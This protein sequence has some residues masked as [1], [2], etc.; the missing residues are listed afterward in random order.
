MAYIERLYR[1]SGVLI[2]FIFND[3]VPLG[4]F[5]PGTGVGAVDIYGFDDYPLGWS[6]AR[7]FLNPKTGSTIHLIEPY[8]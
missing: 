2:P 3:A 8:E 7:E 1:K 5:A 4:N 6:V